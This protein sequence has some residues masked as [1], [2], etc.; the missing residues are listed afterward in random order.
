M[1]CFFPRSKQRIFCSSPVL[2][3]ARYSH[4]TDKRRL[5]HTSHHVL[6][7]LAAGTK[8]RW[9]AHTHTHTM[10]S[11]LYP[12][13][14]THTHTHTHA[15]VCG[16]HYFELFLFTRSFH[17]DEVL[18]LRCC[19]GLW[20][21]PHSVPSGSSLP[22]HE[23]ITQIK[24]LAACSARQ[25]GLDVISSFYGFNSTTMK[26]NN[27]L[28]THLTED[29]DA[30]IKGGGYVSFVT[31]F[32]SW[33]PVCSNRHTLSHLDKIKDHNADIETKR[34]NSEC[35]H[36]WEGTYARTHTHQKG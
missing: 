24:H 15:R 1:L 7:V 5:N 26:K 6:T 36:V 11:Y 34:V 27:T 12:H 33:V 30:H 21:D 32:P 20:W 4:V 25:N 2:L 35:V 23:L 28:I 19:A 3:A 9:H 22:E 8:K 31:C 29:Y 14:H 10:Q 16:V 17:A 13:T 18:V